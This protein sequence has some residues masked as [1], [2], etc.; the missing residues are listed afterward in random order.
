MPCA[1][2]CAT[3][4]HAAQPT[5]AIFTE[6]SVFA[7]HEVLEDVQLA[8]ATTHVRWLPSTEVFDFPIHDATT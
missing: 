6:E 7:L 2:S 1:Q 3:R 4:P 5:T 8:M